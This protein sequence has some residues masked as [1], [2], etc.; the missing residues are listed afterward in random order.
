MLFQNYKTEI[1]P[2]LQ[3]KLNIKNLLALPRVVKVVINMRIS[4]AKEDKQVIDEATE[5][6]KLISGQ[7]PVV[8]RARKSVSGFKLRK[9]DPIGLKVTLRGKK[10]YDFLEKLFFLVLPLLR[11]FK[12]LSLRQ[13]DH[14]GNF[15][16]G[17]EDQ[18]VFP[19]INLDKVKK[20][21]GLQITIVT[22]TKKKSEAESL[23]KVL[24]L[25]FVRQK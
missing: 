23:L 21:R 14:N 7:R 12:G 6:L 5:E 4:E 16:I 11:D 3:K 18:T 2:E 13:F 25:P 15:N 17:L 8:C 22:S 24:G 1:V 9:G 10:M 20:T 19:E